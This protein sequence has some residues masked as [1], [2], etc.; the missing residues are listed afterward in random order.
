MAYMFVHKYIFKTHSI[1]F[2]ETSIIYINQIVPFDTKNG[3]D[4]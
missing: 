2:F 4:F 3:I 1:V